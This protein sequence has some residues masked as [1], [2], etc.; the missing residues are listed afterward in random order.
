MVG[1]SRCVVAA[2]TLGCCAN[3]VEPGTKD[4]GS[5]SICWIGPCSSSMGVFCVASASESNCSWSGST[6]CRSGGVGESYGGML[7]RIGS[8][9]H[10]GGCLLSLLDV[11]LRGGWLCRLMLRHA[12][13]ILMQGWHGLQRCENV[14]ETVV[15]RLN[16]IIR[17]PMASPA[18]ILV[19]RG[20]GIGNGHAF[21]PRKIIA[22]IPRLLR[23]RLR[24][25]LLCGGH[26]CPLLL[27]CCL[28]ESVA[29]PLRRDGATG[30][31]VT[32][33]HTVTRSTSST[34]VMP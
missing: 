33:A 12:R 18:W 32:G 3:G 15:V 19:E 14:L 31:D 34:E 26:H 13:V 17:G 4:G 28:D 16:R 9:L 25:L 23:I 11:Q 24:G 1:G 6:C 22:G 5:L 7:R 8:L 29:P 20:R 21:E 27:G 2:A 30:K 10:A